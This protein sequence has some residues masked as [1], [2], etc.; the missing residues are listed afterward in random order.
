MV[1]DLPR[2]KVH[3][4]EKLKVQAAE[5]AQ[6]ETPTKLQDSSP[7][8]ARPIRKQRQDSMSDDPWAS[9]NNPTHPPPSVAAHT[10]PVSSVSES[11]SSHTNGVTRTTSAFTTRASDGSDS[12][13]SPKQSSD[14]STAGAGWTSYTGNSS[15]DF[16]DSSALGGG[17]GGDG[18]GQPSRPGATSQP[19][20]HNSVVIPPGTGE[21]VTVTMLP[22]K[23]GMFLFQHRNYEV[24]TI[25][26]GSSVV[27]R[28]SDFVWL[29]DCLQKR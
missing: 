5:L 15:G 22:E 10:L 28:Y 25:R 12:K 4:I 14:S 7:A 18:D 23:E 1:T 16:S 17:F 6:P 13:D 19:S 3:Y 20:M 29:L 26:R 2:P 27:R 9:P 11:Y 24:K 21:L 8:T